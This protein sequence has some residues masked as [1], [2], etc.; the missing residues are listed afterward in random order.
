LFVSTIASMF[1]GYPSWVSGAV[2]VVI[3]LAISYLVAEVIA[4]G[5]WRLL[6]PLLGQRAAGFQATPLLRPIRLIRLVVFL[7]V[8]ASIVLPAFELVGF[9]TFAH[10]RPE[11]LVAWLVE[12]GVRI[13][14]ITLLGYVIVRVTG[15]VLS[16][17]EQDFAALGGPDHLEQLKRVRTLGNL[18]RSA[19]FVIVTSV[20]T[21]MILRELQLDIT[22]V[23]TTAGILGLAVGFGAQ[24][25]VKD[26]ISGFF[27]ILEN[28][29]RVGD[30]A[31]I[32]GTG[33]FVEAITLRTI[34]LRDQTGTVHVFPNGSINTLA[35]LTKDFSYYLI[36]LGVDYSEDTDRVVDLLVRIADELRREEPYASSVL[37]PL[38]VIG[39]DDFTESKVVIKVRIKTLPLKQWEV[40]REFR[41]RIKKRFDAEGVQFPY[42]KVTVHV[43]PD[44][45]LAKLAETVRRPAVTSLTA[46]GPATG[47]AAEPARTSG[48]PSVEEAD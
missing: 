34:V 29:V 23:L 5:A 14:L 40:G 26:V 28:Q 42:S 3:T 39:V 38:E 9:R 1:D 6:R 17:F 19:V 21:L 35:N 13:G 22:P 44:E 24:T 11:A 18:V 32:N 7:L 45:G 47:P 48:S 41:R 30:V 8:A 12:S 43:S 16:H 33:G 10:L 46:P 15:L 2:A 27:M 20:A 31:N 36:D 4:R 25:L 37:E